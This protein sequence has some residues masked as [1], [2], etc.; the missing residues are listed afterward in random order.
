[1]YWSS[2]HGK[3][4][5]GYERSHVIIG[6]K[7]LTSIA[8]MFAPENAKTYTIE[9]LWV[10]PSRGLRFQSVKTRLGGWFALDPH[11]ASRGP[12][13]S[14]SL[15]SNTSILPLSLPLSL[16]LLY[17][18]TLRAA[19]AACSLSC[20]RLVRPWLCCSLC[21]GFT[22]FMCCR[23]ISRRFVRNKSRAC[24]WN[25][26]VGVNAPPRWASLLLL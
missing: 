11:K 18:L 7:P 17:P 25:D 1:M 21:S 19:A 6:M 13:E 5:W 3:N 9:S 22:S 23:W 26:S 4:S 14:A 8:S 20:R 2:H 15:S 12:V 16:S 10:S 24:R